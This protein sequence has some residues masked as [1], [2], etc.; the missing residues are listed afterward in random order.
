MRHRGSRK[1]L[2]RKQLSEVLSLILSRLDYCN[3]LL[4]KIQ[5]VINCS[6]SSS[7]K[8]L[9]LFTSLLYDLQRLPISSRIQYKIAVICF[10]I[11]SGT[12]PAYLSELLHLCSPSR[13]LRS[14]AD[15]RI[16]R[17]PRIDRRTL[18]ERSFQCIGPVLWNSLPLSVTHSSSLS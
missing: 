13:C 7:A 8:L 18:G 4:N 12:A 15:T 14:A 16:F 5:G 11:V 10:H 1:P 3:A 2:Q 9:N 6:V 17:V